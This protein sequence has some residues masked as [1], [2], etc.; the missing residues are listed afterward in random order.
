MFPATSNSGLAQ[1]TSYK[2]VLPFYIYGALS[3]LAATLLMF[4]SSSAFLQHYFHPQTLAITHI[5]ALGWGTM[6][7]LGA[8]HQL[9]PV[10]IEGK[11]YSDVLAWLSFVLAATGIPILVYSFYHFFFGWPAETGAILVNAALVFFLINI[12]ISMSKS[13]KENVHAV[14]VF[15]A[16]LWLLITTLVGLFLVYNFTHN[17]LSKDSLSYLPLHAHLGIIGWF[18][19]LV[20]GVGSRLIPLFLISKYHNVKIL[21]W[22]YGMVNFALIAFITI[23]LYIKITWLYF[24]PVVSILATLLMFGY[25]CYKAY[26]DRLRRK[27]DDQLKIS[28]LSVLMMLLP[29][30]FLLI[31]I[32]MLLGSHDDPRLVLTYGFCIFFGWIT[33]IILGMT[34]KTLPFILWNK[35]YHSKA[36]LGKTPNPKELFNNKMFVAMTTFYLA[37][38]VLFAA[39]I[40]FFA[41]FL[42][43]FSSLLLV[44]AA[45]L[46]NG[47]VFKMVFHKPKKL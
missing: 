16:T 25:F 38:F 28:L 18:L 45:L 1:N 14:F 23:F 12:A 17:I 47:N 9:V 30:I 27:V 44:V 3:I 19:L 39:G 33:A 31:I 40:L 4:F 35:T 11:L 24:F 34:F 10:L 7:I 29:L 22:I 36:G 5:M 13:K 43:K 21:W 32:V 2:V 41:G 37:G 46:Y 6:M 20:M 26:Q 15:T 42:L 8:S